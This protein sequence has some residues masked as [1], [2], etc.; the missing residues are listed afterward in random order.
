[1]ENISNVLVWCS[2]PIKELN[3]EDILW[4]LGTGYESGQ[5]YYSVLKFNSSATYGQEIARYGFKKAD[6]I[7]NFWS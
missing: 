2:H 3:K 7:Y 6:N 4:N 1:M 5:F